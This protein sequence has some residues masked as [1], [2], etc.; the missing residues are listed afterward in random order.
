MK[1]D[2]AAQPD[3]ITYSII[4]NGFSRAK[5]VERAAA[6]LR[7]MYDE[8]VNKGNQFVAPD[9]QAFNTVL[10]GYARLCTPDA[11]AQAEAFLYDMRKLHN[12]GLLDI[13][14]DAYTISSG[15]VLRER[16]YSRNSPRLS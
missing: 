16:W 14:P 9:V 13:K 7:T 6:V 3:K 4:M 12:E 2:Q 10:A 15:K 1:N 5:D 11:A 8:F